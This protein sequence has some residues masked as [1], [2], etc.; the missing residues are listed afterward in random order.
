VQHLAFSGGAPLRILA[1]GAH[2]DDIEIGCGWTILRLAGEGRVAAIRWLVLSATGDRAAEARA[3]ASA[4]TNGVSDVRIDLGDARDGF[5]P[6]EYGSIKER[7]EGLKAEPSPDLILAPRRDDLH[8]DHRTVSEMVWT[9]FRD[10]LILEYEIPKWDADLTPPNA[11]VDLSETIVERKAALLAETF[12]SQA[13][14]QWFSRE[15]FVG[16]ARIRGIESR[17]AEGYA[18]A[19]HARK[20]VL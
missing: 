17:A 18:E 20:V 13:D 15:T 5:F 14:R 4:F 11:Y 2:A 3:G 12:G 7:F 19:F 1:I 16:L 9:T 8:Q 6:A 10:H